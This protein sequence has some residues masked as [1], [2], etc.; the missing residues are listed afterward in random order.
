MTVAGMSCKNGS[1]EGYDVG[2]E[3][4]QPAFRKALRRG[5]IALRTFTSSHA[6]GNAGTS[7]P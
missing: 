1:S 6:A 7:R 2:A 3:P 5:Q 4:K